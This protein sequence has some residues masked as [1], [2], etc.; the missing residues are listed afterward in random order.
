MPS[1]AIARSRPPIVLSETDAD[2]LFLLAEQ[3]EGRAVQEPSGLLGELERAQVRPDHRVPATVVGMHSMV[4]FED[5]A[6]GTTRTV[7][8][9]YPAEADIA[10]GR[11]S[12]FTPIGAGLIG[13]AEGQSIEW[14][15][16][17]GKVRA[18][19]VLRVSRA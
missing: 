9:V 16:R 1:K 8:L 10:E 2:R 4:D 3:M 18:L 11:I 13:L 6:H 19:R 17:D 12:V 7:R 15:D 5:A 14:P